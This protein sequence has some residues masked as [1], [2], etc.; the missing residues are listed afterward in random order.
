MPHPKVTPHLGQCK[1][2]HTIPGAE[3]V[4]CRWGTQKTTALQHP[5][6]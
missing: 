6:L 5:L 4:P 3:Q 2:C 1:E